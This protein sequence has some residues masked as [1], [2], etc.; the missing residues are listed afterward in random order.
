LKHNL[1]GLTARETVL[2]F[3]G[4]WSNHIHALAALGR[5]QGFPTIGV[6]RREQPQ[7]LSATLQ[8]ARDWGMQLVF[9]SRGEYR[10]RHDPDYLQALQHRFDPCVIVPEGGA[11]TAG[12][13]GCR[14][15][16]RLLDASGQGYDLVAVACGTGS[17]LAGIAC[18]L[19]E[20]RRVL[21]ISVL[22]G[23][24]SLHSDVS[25]WIVEQGAEPGGNWRIEQGFH[26]GGY[27]RVPAELQRFILEF[28]QVQGIPLDPV[29]TG[30]LFHALY[31]MRSGGGL[32]ASERIIAVHSGGLQG[33][34]GFDWLA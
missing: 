27:A 4:A 10:R 33:R 25:R 26:C 3:G 34:R 32:A 23:Q 29:Y 28:Q 15:I 12:V 17:T 20:W 22:K 6:I 2:T 8:N 21:G 16:V 5:E 31:R 11:N 1:A 19:A 13:T 7:E 24:G 18:E 30:K 14:E 9:V